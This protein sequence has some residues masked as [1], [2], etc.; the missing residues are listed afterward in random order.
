MPIQPKRLRL[1]GWL[2]LESFREQIKESKSIDESVQNLYSYLTLIYGEKNWKE[3]PWTE[4]AEY[5]YLGQDENSPKIAFP[6]LVRG[7]KQER[8]LPPWEYKER[9][10]YVWSHMLAANYGWSLEYI[11]ELV[12]EDALGLIQE[13]VVG[14]N[15]EKEWQWNLSEL[16]YS[17]NVDTKT[18]THQEYPWPSWMLPEPEPVKQTKILKSMLP[19]GMIVGSDPNV[20][21]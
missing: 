19:M 3:F 15:L 7:G 8:K 13:I 17:Y 9:S 1:K 20:K 2:E 21:H 5:V 16:T 18:S 14:E 6:M 10:W 4:I 11:A 12:V